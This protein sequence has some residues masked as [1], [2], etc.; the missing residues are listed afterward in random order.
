MSDSN[1]LWSAE[2]AVKG[3]SGMNRYRRWLEKD[4]QK[5]FDDYHALWKWSVKNP[6]SF[7][8]SIWHYFEVK[9]HS[10]YRQVMSDD[11]MPRA[12]WF[13][14][15]MLNYA[16]HIFRN[17]TADYPALI[18]SSERQEPTPMSWDEFEN[19]TAAL[20]AFLKQEN[21]GR[22]DRIAAFLPNIPE[23][24]ISLMAAISL[25]AIWSSC[26]PD[27]GAES[28]LDRFRQIEPK[29]LIAADGYTYNGKPYNRTE[30]V[31]KIAEALPSVEKVI[32]VPY[33]NK[34]TGINPISSSVLWEEVMR[35]PHGELTFTPVPFSHPIWVLYSSGTT[36][37]PKAITHGHGGM[38]LEHLKYL[39]LHNDVK[40]GEKFFWFSTTGWM[41]WNFVQASLLAGATAVLYDGSPGYPNLERLWKLT[42]QAGIHHFG[43]SA[44]FLLA[45]KKKQLQPGEKY[46]LSALRSIGST[47]SPLPPKGFDYVYEHIKKDV[48][49][50]SMSGGT[51]VCTAWVGGNILKPVAEG[52]IQCRCL[53]ASMVAY[54]ENGH[55]IKDEVGEMVL[56]KPMPCMPIYFWGDDDFER[57]RSAYFNMYPG[58]WRHG[59]WIRITPDD[60]VVI[61]GRSDATLN[62]Q[63][64][65]IGTAEVYRALEE[66]KGLKDSLI[67]NLE[68]TTGKDF[69]PLFVVMEGET[70]LNKSF[71]A[72]INH[73][74]KETYSPRHVPDAIY[75]IPDLPYTLSGKKMEA[76]VK[77]L[78]M[79]VPVEKA[80]NKG[81]MRN[82]E[83]LDYFIEL[84]KQLSREGSF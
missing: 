9:S 21:I 79:G 22:N 83:S 4:Q 1:I 40:P 46:D 28:V 60:G 34:D 30:V 67:I 42:K 77:K 3:Q 73:S 44:P 63:G 54:D 29:V 10:P 52:E 70:P 14:G 25:G 53:G 50:C 19:R 8:E 55:P 72:E 65:R 6:A 66:I 74:L 24:S 39:S 76:P 18:F 20:Q 57:Y 68:L 45:C 82:P 17:K 69:M 64:V 61:L 38:L 81:A 27:F 58:V 23:A 15:S 71:K 62:R 43:T 84:A 31:A 80:V 35:T 7:W 33:L 51:D 11:P 16:E 5:P 49:L 41:M 75:E 56:T 48:W 2:D 78:L 32:L 37:T 36:G 47:G 59:D 26:S 13:E 12:R